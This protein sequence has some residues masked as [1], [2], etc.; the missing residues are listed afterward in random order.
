MDQMHVVDTAIEVQQV[1]V[2]G[3]VLRHHP[4]GEVGIVCF[5]CI[6]GLLYLRQDETGHLHQ[7]VTDP[8]H[9]CAEIR[10]FHA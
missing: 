6:H 7:R 8:C 2:D 4:P 3:L 5:P 1:I 9:L 10:R